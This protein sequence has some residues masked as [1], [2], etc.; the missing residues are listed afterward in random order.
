[1][2][3]HDDAPIEAMNEPS[4]DDR[5]MAMFC[6]LGGIMGFIIPLIIWLMKKDESRFVDHQGKEAIN[7]H[8][9]MLIGHMVGGATMCFTFGLINITVWA[10]SLTF[11]I[12]AGMAA[13]R[14]ERYIYPMSIR[15]IS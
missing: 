5:Q 3:D 2:S 6:H 13:S 8:L 14:G 12:I 11:S 4:A 9:T 10:I 1:M 7:F 15:F